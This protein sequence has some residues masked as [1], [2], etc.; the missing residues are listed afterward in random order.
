M[1]AG[2]KKYFRADPKKLSEK[3]AEQAYDLWA[4]TY[5]SQPG[6]L[7]LDLDEEIFSALLQQV[8][9]SGKKIADIGCGTGRH[10]GKILSRQPAMVKGFDISAAMLDK[11]KEKYPQAAVKKISD[12]LFN[13]EPPGFY[14]LIISTLTVAHIEHIDEALR[15]WSRILKPGGEIILTD[16]HPGLLSIGGKRTFTHRQ[17]SCA[18]INYTHPLEYLEHVFQENALRVIK[19]VEKRIDESMKHYYANQNALPVFERFKNKPVVYGMR[20][21]KDD[22]E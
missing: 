20:L 2:L 3:D 10:W 9:L 19:R 13:E 7:M 14:D 8:P 11:L 21:K 17:R 16:Y 15:S 22:T 5:D 4:E 12:N 18:I 6:N 1:L